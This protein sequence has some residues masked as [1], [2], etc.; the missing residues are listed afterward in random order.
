MKKILYV[1]GSLEVGGAEQ[2]ITQVAVYLKKLG[3]SPEFFI[4]KL[5]DPLTLCLNNSEIP[6]HSVSHSKNFLGVRFFGIGNSSFFRAL[7]LTFAMIKIMRIN[8]Y[9]YVHFFLPLAYILGGLAAIVSFSGPRIMSRRSLNNYQKKHPMYGA[10]E[11]FLHPSM[12]RI[13]AN[14]LAIVKQLNAEGV[15]SEKISLIYN[16]VDTRRFDVDFDLFEARKILGIAENALVFIIVANL[17]PYK[18]HKDLLKALSL[19]KKNLPEP[20]LCLCVGRDDGIGSELQ[21]LAQSLNV[22]S[23]IR[24]LGSRSDVPELLRVSDLAILCSHEE[25]FSNAI[26]EAMAAGLP[27]VA[28]DVGGNAEAVLQEVTGKL[29]PPKNPEALGNALLSFLDP[30]RRKEYGSRGKK[31]VSELFSM[32]TIVES[33]LLLY[34]NLTKVK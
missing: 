28:T 23:H 9:D 4:F 11:K 10:I 34:K 18:G 16:G 31:R 24:W 6:I 22:D 30:S 5:G 25:G 17:I 14:S 33:Y 29:V 20:W 19:I 15:R 32:R 2:H 1:I 21:E 12:D 8:R 26:L 27:V 7:F 13:C 3:W